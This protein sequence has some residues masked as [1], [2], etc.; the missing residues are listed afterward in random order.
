MNAARRKQIEDV[1]ARIEALTAL[2]DE[3]VEAINAISEDEQGYLDNMPDSFRDGDKGEKAQEAIDALSEATTAL[4]DI[5]FDAI[6]G[7]LDTAAQ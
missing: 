1:K 7:H 3:L 6:V 2:R 5:D 4:E